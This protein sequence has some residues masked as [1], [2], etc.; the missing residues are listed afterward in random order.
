MEHVLSP[1]LM[2]CV[3]GW[4]PAVLILV[5][6]EPVGRSKYLGRTTKLSQRRETYSSAPFEKTHSS[7]ISCQVWVVPWTRPWYYL[8]RY[9][10][11]VYIYVD[12]NAHHFSVYETKNTVPFR[13]VQ[14]QFNLQ[15]GLT[16]HVFEQEECTNHD[17]IFLREYSLRNCT[18]R[19][20]MSLITIF[21]RRLTNTDRKVQFSNL[22]SE[23]LRTQESTGLA[24]A[25]Q[26][27]PSPD[28]QLSN[29]VSGA[30]LNEQLFPARI[31]EI[32][33]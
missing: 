5:L 1:R 15:K 3:R 26:S 28:D 23:R 20:V 4:V 2:H 12:G 24:L 25:K 21:E 17:C 32:G 13:S 27:S 6:S 18:F 22:Q 7:M 8:L 10:S 9:V 31:W 30:F 33:I 11:Y 16:C 19:Q 29:R 14:H